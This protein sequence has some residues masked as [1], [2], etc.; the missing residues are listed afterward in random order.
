MKGKDITTTQIKIL[1][2]RY[3]A[4]D[5]V[6][7]AAAAAGMAVTSA[8]NHLHRMGIEMRDDRGQHMRRSARIDT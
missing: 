6:R 7:E 4:G 8:R 1:R 3:L 2:E 5:L